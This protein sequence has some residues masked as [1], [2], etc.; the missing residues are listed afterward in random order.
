M[1]S[2]ALYGGDGPAGGPVCGIARDAAVKGVALD[3]D[4]AGFDDQAADGVDGLLLMVIAVA[5]FALGDVVPDDGAVEI[6]DAPVQRDLR[7]LHR[8]H[9]PESLDVLE[10]G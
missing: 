2:P 8:L 9:D 5:A 1:P 3:G 10:V 7:E 6:I 4:E